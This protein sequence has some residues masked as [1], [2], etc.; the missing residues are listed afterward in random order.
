MRYLFLI[1]HNLKLSEVLKVE[2]L[3]VL[4]LVV[5]GL[6]FQFND[7]HVSKLIPSFRSLRILDFLQINVKIRLKKDQITHE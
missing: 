4:F 1:D 6:N 3:T 2:G 5:K 7:Q